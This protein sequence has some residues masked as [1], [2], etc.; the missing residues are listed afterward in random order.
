VSV[1]AVVWWKLHLLELL[2]CMLAA[3]RLHIQE[4]DCSATV[5]SSPE[6]ASDSCQHLLSATYRHQISRQL[7]CV[8]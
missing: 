1:A 4:Q 7:R 3:L 6:T 2:N 8:L 5:C